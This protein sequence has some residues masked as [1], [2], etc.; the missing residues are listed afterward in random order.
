MVEVIRNLLLQK[1]WF[2]WIPKDAFL[3]GGSVR[4]LLLGKVPKDWDIALW[5]PE[6]VGRL[7]ARQ[8]KGAFIPLGEEFGIYRVVLGGEQ[9]DLTRIDG[10][11]YDDLLKRD[12][13]IN[14]IGVSLD[15]WEFVD[16]FLGRRDLETGVV[17]MTSEENL[18]A[19]PLRI[20]RT[21]RF[22][23]QL[24]FTVE[25]RTLF[26]IRSNS[27]L[28]KHV[29]P[30][31]ITYEL[32]LIL[33][34][35]NFYEMV[36]LMADTGVLF[37]VFPELEKLTEPIEGLEIDVW[38]HTLLALRRLNVALNT[39]EDGPF[40]YYLHRMDAVRDREGRFILVM[41]TMFHDVGKPA[42]YR[43]DEKGEIS[44]HGHDYVGSKIFKRV[45]KRLRMSN[46]LA[47]NI[48]LLIAE[49]MHPHL[50]ATPDVTRR[51]LF[52]FYRRTGVWAFPTI[53]LAYADAL[54]TP[55]RAEGVAGQL[56]LARKLEN[57]LRDMEA[58]RNRP[59]RLV[60]GHDIKALGLPP[61]PIYKKILNEIEEL[62]AEGVIKTREEALKVLKRLVDETLK[63]NVTDT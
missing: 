43:M 37:A 28:L 52:R 63:E 42:T 36:N 2:Q 26:A 21:F 3:I 24:N 57:L 5:E 29:A 39:L 11:I 27:H 40:T 53:L 62:R 22:A 1:E 16:P 25:D 31:R 35:S 54:A 10:N 14:A 45:A 60:T 23:A 33:S 34:Q 50:L 15:R 6:K 56:R 44:F 61:G 32:K 12:L 58:E 17:R 38:S 9:I 18:K 8:F 7:I 51:A 13:T 55:L 59:P 19:D 46:E 4:D 20:L 49:H 41:G 48:A 30:E 47:E